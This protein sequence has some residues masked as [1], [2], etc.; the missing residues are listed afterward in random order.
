[1]LSDEEIRNRIEDGKIE[2]RNV[3][4]FESQ[5]GPASLDLCVGPDY[6]DVSGTSF[7]RDAHDNPGQG[8][9]LEPGQVYRIHTVEWVGLP[10]DVLAHVV[11]K[12]SLQ[13]E[14]LNLITSGTIDPGFE[15]RL[16]LT[17]KNE[18]SERQLM[19]SP[20]EPVVELTFDAL[21]RSVEKPY[22]KDE[23]EHAAGELLE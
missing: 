14:G 16:E 11:G 12:L 10:D 2:V 1:M 17:V 3:D 13:R 20:G 23:S 7:V 5:L 19:L 4:D 22:S 21:S 8:I 6:Q 9:I 18:L 15:N